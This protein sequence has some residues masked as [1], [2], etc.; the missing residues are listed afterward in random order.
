MRVL[1]LGQDDELTSYRVHAMEGAGL[2]VIHPSS[3]KEALA[4]IAQGRYDVAV[5]SYTVASDTAHEF[6]ELIR[7][8]CPKC[9]LVAITESPWEDSKLEPDETVVGKEGP[10][11]LIEAVQRATRKQVDGGRLRR[12]K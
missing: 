2:E 7:Q 11:A 12:V 9:P 10:E 8:N 6:A 5:L 3:R 1:M 4:A